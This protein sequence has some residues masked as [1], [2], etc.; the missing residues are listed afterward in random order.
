MYNFERPI[1]G[2]IWIICRIRRKQCALFARRSRQMA[3]RWSPSALKQLA[4]FEYTPWKCRNVIFFSSAT[5]FFQKL[6]DF[7]S[8]IQFLVMSRCNDEA[9]QLAQQHG[10]MQAYA[11]IIGSTS[12]LQLLKYSVC[13]LSRQLVLNFRH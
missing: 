3:P 1:A 8:A 10:H 6:N 11:D 12:V 5:R 9:F 13:L 7:S 2:S 4:V